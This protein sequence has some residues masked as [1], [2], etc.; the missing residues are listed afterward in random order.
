MSETDLNVDKD[1][2]L[3]ESNYGKLMEEHSKVDIQS[4]R[5]CT[6]LLAVLLTAKIKRFILFFSCI[7]FFNFKNSIFVLIS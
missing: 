2:F 5:K 6:A 7:Y 3:K 4:E 1:A